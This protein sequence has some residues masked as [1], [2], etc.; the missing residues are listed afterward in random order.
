V[1][2]VTGSPD[3]DSL[4][5]ADMLASIRQNVISKSRP[6]KKAHPPIENVCLVGQNTG[7]IKWIQPSGNVQLSPSFHGMQASFPGMHVQALK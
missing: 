3:S 4:S 1:H 6:V 2:K 7:R 5:I